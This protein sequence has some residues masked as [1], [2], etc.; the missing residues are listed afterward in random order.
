MADWPGEWDK[1]GGDGAVDRA[2]TAFRAFDPDWSQLRVA[3]RA[4]VATAATAAATVAIAD[5]VQEPRSL[6]LAAIGVAMTASRM[7]RED[8]AREEVETLA[9]VLVCA[10]A[11]LAVGTVLCGYPWLQQIAVLGVV[12]AAVSARRWGTRGSAVGMVGFITFFFSIFLRAPAKNL[13]W[14]LVDLAVATATTYVSAF[15]LLRDAPER[16]VRSILDAYV[17]SARIAVR[18][19]ARG[20][21]AKRELERLHLVALA[22]DDALEASSDPAARRARLHSMVLQAAIERARSGGASALEEVR[23]AGVELHRSA[24]ELRTA[25][26]AATATAASPPSP[27]ASAPSSLHPATRAAWQAVAAV[28]A[29]S[30]AGRAIS[31]QRWYWA[32][33]AAYVMFVRGTTLSETLSRGWARVVGTLA[34]VVSGTM[35]GTAVGSHTAAALALAF[36]SIFMGTYLMQVS[37]GVFVFTVTLMVTA[38][39]G[40]L[41]RFSDAILWL[42]L[43]E[44]LAGCAAG[45]FAAAALFPSHARSLARDDAGALLSDLAGF[46][47]A[48]VGGAGPETRH[49]RMRALEGSLRALEEEASPLTHG[50]LRLANEP[51]RRLLQRLGAAV[52]F[53]RQLAAI[54]PEENAGQPAVAAAAAGVALHARE[55]SAV[56]R[57]EQ[58]AR[59]LTAE[60]GQGP[61]ASIYWI[62]W[63]DTCL[64]VVSRDLERGVLTPLRSAARGGPE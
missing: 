18:E 48:V 17:R 59:A 41:G 60:I 28:G 34:G 22:L 44:T 25:N 1:L 32:V 26:D 49:D 30:I 7:V 47:D 55:L 29:A 50:L 37:Y 43:A 21:E 36:A 8:R 45:A 52:A 54:P 2:W 12:F 15:V 38:L 56:I 42:R 53:A 4:L 40:L 57:G 10:S 31:E 14:M 19:I 58:A 6:T 24:A 51:L 27:P 5:A 20:A 13:P 11:S 3:S 63:I 35:I 33:L 64:S 23:R 62:A 39:Y 16:R 46:L 9:I 61:P